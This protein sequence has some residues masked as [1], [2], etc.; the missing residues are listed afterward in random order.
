M[1]NHNILQI[2]VFI[3]VCFGLS[4]TWPLFSITMSAL[5]YDAWMA[6]A[7]RL[8]RVE[9]SADSQPDGRIPLSPPDLQEILLSGDFGIDRAVR[10]SQRRI[11]NFSL[12]ER[13]LSVEGVYADAGAMAFFG[14]EALEGASGPLSAPNSIALS[15]SV[16]ERLSPSGGYTEL[17]G[18]PLTVAD[19]GRTL[20]VR[21]V[22]EDLP[23][24]THLRLEA[25]ISSATAGSP[26]RPTPARTLLTHNLYTYVKLHP[27]ESLNRITVTINR[28]LEN[29]LPER[30]EQRDL[31]IQYGDIVFVP[32]RDI[33]LKNSGLG[34]IKPPGN[35][36]RLY[37]L[38]FIG[39]FI[40]LIILMDVAIYQYGIVFQKS[41][42]FGIY[43][44]C[45]A[46]W[47][48]IFQKYF[49]KG[50]VFGI[51]AVAVALLFIWGAGP[52]L[53]SVMN[54]PLRHPITVNPRLVITVSLLFASGLGAATALPAAMLARRAPAR[55]L[56]DDTAFGPRSRTRSYMVVFQVGIAT[57]LI[58]S[59]VLANR[60]MHHLNTIPRGFELE[61]R[62]I[63][64]LPD[65][66][67]ANRGLAFK[68]A[69][70]EV[71]SIRSVTF[72]G[73][74]LPIQFDLS[75]PLHRPDADASVRVDPIDVDTRF[76]Q[77]LGLQV[78]AGRWFE[79]E[80]GSD[81]LKAGPGQF[82]R[83]GNILLSRNAAEGLGFSP[84][85]SAIGQTLRLF[86]PGGPAAEVTVIGIAEN[87]HWGFAKETPRPAAYVMDPQTEPE[88]LLAEI[89]NGEIA[90]AR[91]SLK[92]AWTVF[93][94]EALPDETNIRPL[95]APFEE[96]GR[97]ERE[98]SLVFGIFSFIAVVL[99]AFGFF[100]LALT[101]VHRNLRETAIRRVLG[102]PI[103]LLHARMYKRLLFPVA[104]AVVI[105]LPAAWTYNT[106]WLEGF[107]TR[108][109]FGVPELLV[110]PT[111]ILA[112]VSLA[113]VPVVQRAVRRP[114]IHVLGE[115]RS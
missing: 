104:I 68:A 35:K 31:S 27:S 89:A 60:Q 82:R 34:E 72:S 7:D 88:Q 108:V 61:D 102:A 83:S 47:R 100:A 8:M 49:R 112:A 78:V 115:A 77:T 90:S 3:V 52:I 21:A 19:T 26:M 13:S 64:P 73:T 1:R 39:I 33:Y 71:S 97:K 18:Q 67:D 58:A 96:L 55:L 66:F 101:I 54:E 41:R 10:L 74:L 57:F 45:G 92:E 4:A 30:S 109:H 65:S 46:T 37:T 70:E 75:R 16:A 80:R 28:H 20:T 111:I 84:A 76:A 79:G 38:I 85:K 50:F 22:F 56:A 113:V 17:I 81:S 95:V 24:E 40:I 106:D 114:P 14:I 103:L 15:R 63:M 69:L 29:L 32:V 91:R 43:M 48:D 59:T 94:S 25:L 110:S 6:D 53:S 42:E 98:R 23:Q 51:S 9:V 86:D 12:D 93:F 44:C 107:A 99:S 2:C 105:A 87:A 5:Q 11:F 36:Q 62:I